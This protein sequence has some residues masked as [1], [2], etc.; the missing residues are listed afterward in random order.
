MKAKDKKQ[1]L[2]GLLL[3]VI[4]MILSIGLYRAFATGMLPEYNPVQ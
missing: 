4:W 2:M 3:L 1:I